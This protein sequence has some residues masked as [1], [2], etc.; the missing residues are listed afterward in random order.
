VRRLPARVQALITGVGIVG[1]ACL[2]ARLPDLANWGGNDA[3]AFCLLT[4]GI[5]LTEQFQIP[6]RFGTETLNFS[7]T[8]ALW[9]GALV[10]ARPSVVTCALAAGILIGQGM[11]RWAP[12]KVAFNAGQFVIALTAAQL[13][14]GAVRSASVLQPMTFVAVGLGMCAYGA[15]NAGLVALV[16]SRVQEKPFRTVLMPPLAENA[17][18]Y[19][20]NTALGLAAAVLWQSAPSA[21]PVLVLP[22]AMCFI[23]YKSLVEGVLANT[24]MR[25]LA[26]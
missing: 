23:A 1:S 4:A 10:L 9:V 8:E 11:R 2:L 17:V 14:V 20:A 21:V 16:I 26:R 7:L 5:I 13:V 6:M 25:E 24:R 3:A 22:L 19:A 12:H 15:I 18:H